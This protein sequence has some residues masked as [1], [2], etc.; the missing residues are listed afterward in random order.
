MK[1]L[2]RK[3]ESCASGVIAEVDTNIAKPLEVLTKYATEV[4]VEIDERSQ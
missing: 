4:I 2:Y 3:F 1:I